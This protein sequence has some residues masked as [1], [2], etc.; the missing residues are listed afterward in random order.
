[1]S[2]NVYWV[3]E[4][5]INPG[6]FED[7]KTLV[8]EMVEATERNEMG[9]LSYEYTISDDQ[10]VCHIF[11]RYQD[12][13]AAMTHSETFGVKFATR[14]MDV[15]KIMRC[16]IYGSPSAQVKDALAGM[17]PVYMAPFKGFSR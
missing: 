15:V 11:E 6:R 1:M 10:Q 14:F 4:L 8:T 2:E 9:T 17:S 7:F 5:A 12:S 3:L 13:A 16:V